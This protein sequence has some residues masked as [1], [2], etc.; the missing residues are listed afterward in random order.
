MGERNYYF[1]EK[2]KKGKRPP[3]NFRAQ[4][5]HVITHRNIKKGCTVYSTPY[6]AT[7]AAAVC[8]MGCVLNLIRFFALKKTLTYNLQFFFS[9]FF[10][11]NID[12]INLIRCK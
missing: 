2:K 1:C 5:K 6:A 10:F 9:Y 3:L 7:A 11:F 8:G 12:Q 4:Q